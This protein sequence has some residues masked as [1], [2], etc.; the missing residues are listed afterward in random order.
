MAVAAAVGVLLLPA[1]SGGD[2]QPAQASPWPSVPPPAGFRL[3]EIGAL[4]FFAPFTW[5]RVGPEGVA[6]VEGGELELA[7]RARGA[8]GEAVPVALALVDPTPVRSA[9]KE[10]DNLVRIKRDVQQVPDVRSDQV[11]LPGFA[12]AVLVSYDEELASGLTQHT[13]VLVGDLADGTLVTLTVKAERR[14]Y[15]AD[16]LEAVTRTAAASTAS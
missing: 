13:D 4:S 8:Q 3:Q 6:A 10:A 14:L 5:E 7:L 1:C 11:I 9:L 15:D 12:H 2:Q 16:E